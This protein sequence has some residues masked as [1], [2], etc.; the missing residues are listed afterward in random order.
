MQCYE[1]TNLPF[2]WHITRHAVIVG[3]A[4]QQ[5]PPQ[6]L[7]HLPHIIVEKS[8]SR[9]YKVTE[10]FSKKSRW[11]QARCY[12]P[13]THCQVPNVLAGSWAV[14]ETKGLFSATAKKFWNR[15]LHG[16]GSAAAWNR[17]ISKQTSG[18]RVSEHLNR[19]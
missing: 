4:W 11:N 17:H 19:S 7:R 10:V 14:S 15:S 6:Q 5:C 1:L 12:N 16:A 13:R 8:T 2:V 3:L 9:G 18:H